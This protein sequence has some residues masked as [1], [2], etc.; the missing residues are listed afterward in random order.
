MADPKL[1]TRVRLHDGRVG[2]ILGIKYTGSTTGKRP[3]YIVKFSSDPADAT[4][5]RAEDFVVLADAEPE[6]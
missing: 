3:A 4:F 5:C 6:S 1:R 2:E